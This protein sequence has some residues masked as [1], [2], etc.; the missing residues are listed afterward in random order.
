MLHNEIFNKRF[1]YFMCS[2]DRLPQQASVG[3]G[4]LTNTMSVTTLSNKWQPF[5]GRTLKINETKIFFVHLIKTNQTLASTSK[6]VPKISNS[7]HTFPFQ[8][9]KFLSTRLCSTKISLWTWVDIPT[10]LNLWH[11]FM[12]PKFYYGHTFPFQQ[13]QTSVTR[14][15]FHKFF[16]VSHDCCPNFLRVLF[17]LRST[18]HVNNPTQS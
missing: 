18:T 2:T 12:F 15:V 8:K 9:L 17:K 3:Q 13:F 4:T 1:E 6:S 16:F 14:F 11:T 7:W 5:F 10:V